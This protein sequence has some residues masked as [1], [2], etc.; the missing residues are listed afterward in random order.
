MVLFRQALPRYSGQYSVSTLDL[1]LAVP[2]PPPAAGTDPRSFTRATL[3]G[4]GRPALELETVLATVFYPANPHQASSPT[5]QPWLQRPVGQTAEGYARFLNFGKPWVL[6]ALFWLV[7][8]R[9]RLPV[10][11]NAPIADHL[12]SSSADTLLD[13]PDTAAF[14]LVVFSHGLSGTRTTYRCVLGLGSLPPLVPALVGSL[15][16]SNRSQP[17]VRRDRLARLHRRRHRAPRWLGPRLG[18]PPRQRP[19][20]RRRLPAPRGEPQV[21]RLALGPLRGHR[22]KQCQRR[23]GP[24]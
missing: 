20:A 10:P 5:R 15:D 13:G 3:K 19:R 2:P 23:D 8:A 12:A 6:K 9:I 24:L 4:S 14:P 11:S 1:E 17:L 16:P 22:H 21:S 18:R 7:G